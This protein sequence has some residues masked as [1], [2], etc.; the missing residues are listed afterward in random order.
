M[1]EVRR[2]LPEG[3]CSVVAVDA[4]YRD[5]A[6]LQPAER[7]TSNFDH[8]DSLDWP[9]LKEHVAR[10]LDGE[11]ILA[12]TYDFANHTRRREV[13]DIPSAPV[14]VVEGILALYDEELNALASVRAY[15]DA[16]DQSCLDRRIGRDTT[17]RGRTA[18]SV[19]AQFEATVL[20]MA[21]QFVK[22]TRDRAG[23]ILDGTQP[24]DGLAQRVL[25]LVEARR[26]RGLL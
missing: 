10:L 3:A 23:L 21:E 12:P 13:L 7:A 18:E 20:P 5:L 9:L 17:E 4:Y 26:R 1:R 15:V 22:C 25:E 24:I 6:H 19:R 2:R 14:I 11:S 8:P 16:P